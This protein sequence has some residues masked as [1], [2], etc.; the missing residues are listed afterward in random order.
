MTKSDILANLAKKFDWLSGKRNFSSIREFIDQAPDLLDKGLALTVRQRMKESM[1]VCRQNAKKKDKDYYWT[2]AMS[3][4]F[5][6]KSFSRL[7]VKWD[8]GGLVDEVLKIAEEQSFPDVKYWILLAKLEN[9]TL[10]G[11]VHK[12]DKEAV[13]MEQAI[14]QLKD[15]NRY[16]LRVIPLFIMC[17]IQKR[18][19]DEAKE[20]LN[21]LEGLLKDQDNVNIRIQH[22]ILSGRIALEEG[23]SSEALKSFQQAVDESPQDEYEQKIVASYHLAE[24]YFLGGDKDK[25]RSCLE[26]VMPLMTEGVE[27]DNSVH[28]M[29]VQRIQASICASDKEEEK[30]EK[31]FKEALAC[32]EKNDNLVAY[33]KIS[34]A[35]GQFFIDQENFDK[36]QAYLEEASGKY[37]MLKNQHQVDKVN[38]LRQSIKEKVSAP[39]SSPG[40]SDTDQSEEP[41]QKVKALDAFMKMA[42][43]NLDL[44]VVL[45]NVL[46]NIM[47]STDADRGFVVLLDENN[48]L[49]SQVIRT[50]KEMDE[51]GGDLLKRFSRS[52]TDRVLKSKKSILVNDIKD[53][54]Q[55]AS[56]QSIAG[57]DIRSVVCVP[58][59]KPEEDDQIIGLI[60]LD[61]QSFVGAFA[62]EDLKLVESLSEYASIAVI[63]AKMHFGIKKKL[64]NTQEQLIHSE[65]MATIGILAGGVAHE[66]NT[67][68]GTILNNTELLM[69]DELNDDQKDCLDM[70]KQGTLR[71]KTIVEQL[72]KYSRKT[73][74]EFE[75]VDINGVISDACVI[76]EHQF[77]VQGIKIQKDFSEIPL[78]KGNPTE[79]SQVV[80]NILVNSRD[81]IVERKVTQ[82]NQGVINI[83]S[84]SDEAMITVEISDN[85]CGIPESA[86]AKIYDPFYTSKEVGQGTGL[87]LSIVQKIIQR[88][89][90]RLETSSEVDKGTVIT[91]KFII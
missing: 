55:L 35:L 38:E 13:A 90:G 78:M 62:E 24:A 89:G 43:G 34:L 65:K 6:L 47:Q 5:Y 81:A 4:C 11:R 57:M 87:G 51:K 29:N 67:P 72:L 23:N 32:A 56:S 58:L 70:I 26:D 73:S 88:H 36:A 75:D 68:L 44:D 8:D 20:R 37:I 60:Y 52:I 69:M 40:Q 18:N 27:L 19:F 7:G 45:N 39:V 54:R 84:V 31:I 63:N 74:T 61:R 77:N 79:L 1:E 71:C 10:T 86:M 82:D 3:A 85:G 41:V 80:T 59:K 46:D 76:L 42:I 17:A 48:E 15:I 2:F 64:E 28:Q 12:C 83:K 53:D 14:A 66:I 22:R 16:R 30:A 21:E 33:A 50:K 49:Y 9:L 91:I 25:A